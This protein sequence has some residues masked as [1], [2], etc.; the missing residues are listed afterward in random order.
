MQSNKI[1]EITSA[2]KVL[3]DLAQLTKFRLTVSVVISSL[4]G[5]FLAIDHADSV[6]YTHLTL[7]TILLV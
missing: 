4:A 1:I 3:N 6:S 7:P 2:H 5:Y